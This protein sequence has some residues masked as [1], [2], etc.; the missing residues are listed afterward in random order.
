MKVL[1]LKLI[2]HIPYSQS[3]KDKRNVVRTLKDRIWSRFRVAIAEVESQDSIREAILG[4]CCCSNDRVLL[5]GIMNKIVTFID[6]TYPSL[7]YDSNY[8]IETY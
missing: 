7:L 5:E 3:L 1:I 8:I 6:N 4:I 2:L